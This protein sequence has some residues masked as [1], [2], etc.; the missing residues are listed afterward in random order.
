MNIRRPLDL[1]PFY[2]NLIFQFGIG[3]HLISENENTM[4]GVQFAT[5]LALISINLLANEI[6]MMQF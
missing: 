3:A 2:S 4:H 6:V 5:N 1:F